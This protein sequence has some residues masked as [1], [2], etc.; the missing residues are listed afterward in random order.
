MHELVL[1]RQRYAGLLAQRLLLGLI[2]SIGTPL[3]SHAAT[4]YVA[5]AGLDT[6]SC[7]QAGFRTSAKLTIAAALSCMTSGDTLVIGNGTYDEYIWTVQPPSGSAGA[8]T[9]IKAENK[10]QAVLRPTSVSPGSAVIN[11][12]DK[13]YITFDGLV[14]DAPFAI[15]NGGFYLITSDH[16]TI[17]NGEIRNGNN[18]AGACNSYPNGI[19]MY[20]GNRSG[21]ADTFDQILSND[22]HDNGA[23]CPGDGKPHGFGIYL[24]YNNNVIES[25]NIYSNSRGGMQV[26]AGAANNT[27]RNNRLYSHSIG[28]GLLLADGV[29]SNLVYNNLIYSNGGSG[30]HLYNT[31]TG[32]GV[33]NN[34]I[35]G[36]TQYCV[37]VD[38][39]SGTPRNN[40][41]M[42]NLCYRNSGGVIADSGSGTMCT[43]NV[44]VS[45]GEG[46]SSA[47]S[48]ASSSS[49][50]QFVDAA[51]GDFRLLSGSSAIKVGTNLSNTFNMDYSGNKRPVSTAW[52]VGAFIYI[53][54]PLAAPQNLRLTNQTN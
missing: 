30:V 19:L 48:M 1:N 37:F 25:N 51:A 12:K 46:A 49:N 3:L 36:N 4:Y 29:A 15:E 33:Y 16:I 11:V 52:D 13:S 45:G 24:G 32:T 28:D 38:N 8:P 5:K 47:C 53:E 2:V 35:Y 54:A 44:G 27:I 17:Q 20:G 50:P 26:R 21:G 7:T 42:N 40:V 14:A 22:I 31:S 6:N 43:Y 18:A 9:T 41:I 10:N 23:I 34:T 39:S